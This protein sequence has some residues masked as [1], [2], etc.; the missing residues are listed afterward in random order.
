[1]RKPNVAQGKLSVQS[2]QGLFV[3]RNYLSIARGPIVYRGED[4]TAP[5]SRPILIDP[6]Q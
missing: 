1:M 3:L 6:V 5:N 2:T 4:L